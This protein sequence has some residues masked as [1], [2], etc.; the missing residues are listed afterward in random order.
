MFLLLQYVPHGL[1]LDYQA[2]DRDPARTYALLTQTPL[3]GYLSIVRV[4]ACLTPAPDLSDGLTGPDP[5]APS[6]KST[7]APSSAIDSDRHVLYGVEFNKDIGHDRPR[8]TAVTPVFGSVGTSCVL[9]F[10][11]PPLDVGVRLLIH[12]M[13]RNPKPSN[14]P[15]RDLRRAGF[16][17]SFAAVVSPVIDFVAG[18]H[19]ERKGKLK[20]Y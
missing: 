18:F 12:S 14:L 7:S 20:T 15:I 11:P 8:S 2:D 10:C 5:F 17:T 13:I 4:P 6:Q 1:L 9:F 16:P 19:C 3:I